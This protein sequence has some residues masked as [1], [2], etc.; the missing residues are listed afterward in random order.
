MYKLFWKFFFTIWI[1]QLIT[2]WGAG[3]AIWYIRHHEP[4]SE[5]NLDL[6]NGASY[7]LDPVLSSL[8]SEGI[9]ATAEYLKK[10]F[11]R[12]VYVVDT[13]TNKELLNRKIPLDFLD[14]VRQK[15]QQASSNH[16]IQELTLGDRRYLLFVVDIPS[17]WG[18]KPLLPVFPLTGATLA[19]LL[20]AFL[21]ARHFSRPIEL[22]KET[23]EQVGLG[24]F[25]IQ[26][27]TQ[28]TNRQD[29]LGELA[30]DIQHM[31]TRLGKVIDSQTR[32]LHTISHELRSP[33]TRLQMAT[34]LLRQKSSENNDEI[35]R[36]E[37]ECK[38]I[39]LL[40]GQLLT[41]SRLDDE[42]S[43]QEIETVNFNPLINEII[44]NAKFEAQSLQKTVI[45]QSSSDLINVEGNPILLYYA[46]ENVIRNALRHARK[47]V[48]I[49]HQLMN[50]AVKIYIIDD[51]EGVDDADLAQ[52]T[53]P[54]YRASNTQKNPNMQGF[55]LGLAITQK[56]FKAHNGEVIFSNLPNKTGFK[57]ELI[58]PLTL[59]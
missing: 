55:G 59:H 37:R 57:V 36:I 14:L 6:S 18:N 50:N 5:T 2:I 53:Q 4:L 47:I 44:E 17:P 45:D 19:S 31:T 23:V 32:L 21:L 22:L 43:K 8:K 12:I 28:L 39:D 10:R 26:L 49:G 42:I 34:G 30:V 16:A 33:L 51:G 41:L 38:R 11:R 24:K 13:S 56:T 58:L 7:Y 46:I 3:T 40:I 52:I 25:D 35:E 9:S 27:H 1:A 29:S 48:W 20:F 54:F 15:T